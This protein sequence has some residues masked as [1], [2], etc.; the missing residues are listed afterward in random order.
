MPDQRPMGT[1]MPD[2]R[3]IRDLDMPHRRPICLIGDPSET[4]MHVESNWNFNTFKYSYFYKLFAYVYTYIGIIYWGMTISDGSPI[5][6]IEV[7]H[8]SPIRCVGLRWVSNQACWSPMGLWSSMLVY[9]GSPMR[10]V[11]L[12]WVFDRSWMGL[13]WISYNNI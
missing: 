11:G 2:R 8:G 4:D 3:P 9:D 7:S 10:H 12:W 6:H 1:N 13:R 5:N